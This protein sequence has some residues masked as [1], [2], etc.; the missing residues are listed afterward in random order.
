MFLCIA[1]WL[2][3]SIWCSLFNSNTDGPKRMK[4]KSYWCPIFKGIGTQFRIFHSAGTRGHPSPTILCFFSKAYS[5]Q[6][7]YQMNSFTGIFWQHF[8]PPMLPPCIDLNTPPPPHQI[9]KSPP[10]PHVLSTCGKPCYFIMSYSHIHN[11]LRNMNHFRFCH[12]LSVTFCLHLIVSM[13]SLSKKVLNVRL[14]CELS[15]K[16]WRLYY[17]TANCHQSMP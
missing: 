17:T 13:T 15:V 16:I 3:N 5:W 14:T 6:L 1:K 7:Y 12:H 4:I 9:L 11:Y 2:K 10:P 8:K